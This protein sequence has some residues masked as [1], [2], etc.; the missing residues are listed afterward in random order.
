MQPSRFQ[1]N[2]E[3]MQLESIVACL[4]APEPQSYKSEHTVILVQLSKQEQDFRAHEQETSKEQNFFYRTRSVTF[5]THKVGWKQ[6]Q[7]DSQTISNDY[8]NALFFFL[9][10]ASGVDWGTVNAFPQ[11]TCPWKTADTC[12]PGGQNSSGKPTRT[13][14]AEMERFLSGL[15]PVMSPILIF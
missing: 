4:D 13:R 1:G 11:K 2:N 12:C 10:P 7:K 15:S 9:S 14:R 5:V 3:F 6:V 8:L